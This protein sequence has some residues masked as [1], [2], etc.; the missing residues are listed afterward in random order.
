MKSFEYL[1]PSSLEEACTMLATPD[2]P[3]KALAGGTDLIVQMKQGGLEPH[4][5]VSLRDVPGLDGLRLDGD[6]N[7]VIGSVASLGAVENSPDVLA[8]FPGIAEAASFVG[9]MQ[10]RSRATVGGNLC[11]AAPSADTAPI[12]LAC[13]ATAVITDGKTERSLLLEDFF[14]GPG[15]TV[16][17]P[18]ELLKAIVVPPLPMTSF[19]RYFKSFRSA[20]DC[21]TVGVAAFVDFAPGSAVVNDVRLA[22]GAVAPTPIRARA[23]EALL[24]GKELD[25]ALIDRASVE[26]AGDAQPISDLR[27]SAEYRKVLVEV[28][29][30]RALNAARA[31][32]EKG[33]K[34]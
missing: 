6:G 32:A 2:G 11:N 3:V 23:A 24:L 16:L 18:G 20:M 30:R 29:S 28:L 34:A 9:S 25:G 27:A 22:L 13:G 21:C 4:A 8:A 15:Q 14:T 17:E 10:V 7:L 26:A 19:A 5:L 12:L 33:A 31:W 1:R